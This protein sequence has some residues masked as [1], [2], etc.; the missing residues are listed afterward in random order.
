MS[1]KPGT[2][3]PH[4]IESAEERLEDQR[5]FVDYALSAICSDETGRYGEWCVSGPHSQRLYWILRREDQRLKR[6]EEKAAKKKAEAERKAADI[7]SPCPFCGTPVIIWKSTSS[8]S[9]WVGGWDVGCKTGSCNVAFTG[10]DN[11][12]GAKIKAMNLGDYYP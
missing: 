3:N 10:A 9:K 5:E 12:K 1:L 7:N 8:Y 4:K 11:E 2:D 6:L